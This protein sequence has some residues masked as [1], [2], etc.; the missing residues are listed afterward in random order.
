MPYHWLEARIRYFVLYST[1]QY[2]RSATSN[3]SFYKTHPPFSSTVLYL[4]LLNSRILSPSPPSPKSL[5]WRS[6]VVTNPSLPWHDA[7]RRRL[8]SGNGYDN[9]LLHSYS[10]S[11][12]QREPYSNLNKTSHLILSSLP[13]PHFPSHINPPP[14]NLP[15]YFSIPLSS[16][17]D[18][19]F[20]SPL[21]FQATKEKSSHTCYTGE[22]RNSCYLYC[23]YAFQLFHQTPPQPNPTILS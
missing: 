17:K 16:K 18:F 7:I 10:H 9:S 20:P 8:Q 15:T 22:V 1:V 12:C 23:T 3:R 13:L 21:T 14:K 19:F 2:K 6:S 4:T 5:R 11:Q